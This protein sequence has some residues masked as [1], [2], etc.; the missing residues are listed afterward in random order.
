MP[1]CPMTVPGEG[2]VR[3]I[4]I[5]TFCSGKILNFLFLP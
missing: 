3:S 4:D 2:M 5:E 1:S